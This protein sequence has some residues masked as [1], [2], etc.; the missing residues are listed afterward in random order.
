MRKM[1]KIS[2]GAV[3]VAAALVC[4]GEAR[5]ANSSLS[6]PSTELV[7][8]FDVTSGKASYVIVSNP[9]ASSPGGGAKITTHWVFWGEDCNELADY[10]ICLTERDT[11]VVDPTNM[12]SVDENNQENGPTINLSG[13]RGVITVTA[14]ETD[15]NCRPFNQTGEVLSTDGIVGTFTVADTVT[16]Y[17][18]GNDAY[19][20]NTDASGYS[21]ELPRHPTSSAGRYVLQT[22][23]P[24]TLDA[25]F[26]ALT[27]LQ[28]VDR[29]A[30]PKDENATYT[31]AF[32]DNLEI[33][34]S[35]PDIKL[36]CLEFRYLAGNTP[37]LIPDYATPDSSGILTLTPD[38]GSD[39]N[40]FLYA[41][42][43]EAVGV[44]GASSSG[45]VQLD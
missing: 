45:K 33:A 5:A 26:V 20:L 12:R 9:H 1:T 43:G 28:I 37:S 25:S 19:G 36:D 17:S 29:V 41:V 15:A 31:A 34:T 38:T 21:V 13:K 8:P 42:V 30:E 24:K 16:G 14:Y 35:L 27:H 44:F 11:I 40:D 22:L 10:S 23:N 7:M 39:D 2:M 6:Q 4:S 3:A 18:F 32:Y